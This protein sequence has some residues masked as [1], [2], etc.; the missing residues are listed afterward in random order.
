M[1][2]LLIL[3]AILSFSACGEY[4]IAPNQV[5]PVT[6]QIFADNPDAESAAAC[7]KT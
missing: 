3:L 2:L 5:A 6:E 7:I 4:G 1:K